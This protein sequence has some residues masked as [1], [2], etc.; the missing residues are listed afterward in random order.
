MNTITLGCNH[1]ICICCMSVFVAFIAL[2]SRI[3]NAC[4]CCSDWC[5]ARIYSS[6]FCWK[7]IFPITSMLREPSRVCIYALYQSVFTSESLMA[8]SVVVEATLLLLFLRTA[9]FFLFVFLW[10]R[11][12]AITATT[13]AYEANAPNYTR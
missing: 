3:C 12:F 8:F 5:V 9:A 4:Y 11:A 10:H 13:A 2:Y 6:T 7:C 1:N